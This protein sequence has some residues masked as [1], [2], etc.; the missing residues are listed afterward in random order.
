[1]IFG[2]SR[3]IIQNNT[4]I[5]NNL[6]FAQYVKKN[7][8]VQLINVTFVRNVFLRNLLNIFSSC[9]TSLINIRMV[10]NSLDWMFLA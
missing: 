5:E 1:M 8:I 7:S 10:G 2:N 6:Q 9:S 3:A 4:L